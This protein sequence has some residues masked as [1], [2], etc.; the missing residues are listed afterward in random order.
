M[1]TRISRGGAFDPIPP[2][3]PAASGARGAT[4]W[5]SR[6]PTTDR[7]DLRNAPM[8]QI[9]LL[10]IGVPPLLMWLYRVAFVEA[11]WRPGELEGMCLS[12]L[13]SVTSLVGVILIRRGRVQWAIRQLL[14]LIGVST[15][16]AYATQGASP[17][18][19]EEPLL[20]AWIA[21]SGLMIGRRASWLMFGAI[22]L[23]F[24]LGALHDAHS[25]RGPYG[26]PA[27]VAAMALTRGVIF[28]LITIVIDR[29]VATL[30]A[31]LAEV[32]R[33]EAAEVAARRR[34][35]SEM[36]ERRQA[37]EKLIHA[38]KV[39]AVGRLS[40][41]I[42]HD[43][44]HILTLLL[45]YA[46]KARAATDDGARTQALDGIDAAIRRAVLLT[47]KLQDFSRPEATRVERF[48]VVAAL[49]DLVPLLRQS[50]RPG[51]RLS[52][53][54]PDDARDVV[55]DASQLD[56]AVLNIAANANL[57]MPDGGEFAVA[58]KDDAASGCL[59]IEFR[60]SGHGMDEEVKSRVFEPFFTTR[61][62]GQGIGLGLSVA[63]SMTRALGGDISVDSEPGKG[64][65]FRLRV[66]KADA[67]A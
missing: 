49:R 59:E 14:G 35:E 7:I 39:E 48:D 17:Q 24:A 21:L 62:P 25:T 8:L 37:E 55:F 52:F 2:I 31:A 20:V 18:T 26:A 10:L 54:L 63:R 58:L 64:A 34:L 50:F 13:T 41:G 19:F 30:R 15:I 12:V 40:S 11:P 44:N 67:R 4:G 66:P 36:A 57:A 27:T 65:T 23:A 6:I 22:A 56:L 1:S 47:R 32:S 45:G 28:L 51:V 61:P 43:F 53:D 9:V 5:L 60:D 29:G 38:Q 3:A 33:S 46:G 42:A 16:Y